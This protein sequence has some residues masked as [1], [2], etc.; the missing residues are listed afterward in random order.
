MALVDINFDPSSRQLR[1]FGWIATLGFPLV[2][3]MWGYEG[4]SL[5][6]AA[7]IGGMCA[8]LGTIAPQSLKYPFLLLSLLTWPIGIVVGEVAVHCG[9]GIGVF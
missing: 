5:G 4:I 7:A 2:A 6:W 8:L 1:Q 3:W 9:Y